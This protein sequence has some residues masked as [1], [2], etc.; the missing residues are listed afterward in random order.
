[1][2]N[3]LSEWYNA[4]ARYFK[5]PRR[6]GWRRRL[7][8]GDC[9]FGS[10]FV[11]WRVRLIKLLVVIGSK[12]LCGDWLASSFGSIVGGLVR[13]SSAMRSLLSPDLGDGTGPLSV[14]NIE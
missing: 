8:L 3:E 1:M 2:P 12:A 4:L 14:V 5:R 10:L 7:V 13:K 9:R 6:K 11:Q